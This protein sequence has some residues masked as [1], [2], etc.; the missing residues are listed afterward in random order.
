[1]D[2]WSITYT[3]LTKYY[4]I[5]L[6]SNLDQLMMNDKWI[7][8]WNFGKKVSFTPNIDFSVFDFDFIVWKWDPLTMRWCMLKMTNEWSHDLRTSHP[9]IKITFK[10][11]YPDDM[12]KVGTKLGC[13]S[14]PYSITFNLKVWMTTTFIY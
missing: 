3:W 5:L 7:T 2:K 4:R 10:C 1:M 12:K 13:D 9:G 14:C 6:Q 11:L 8:W